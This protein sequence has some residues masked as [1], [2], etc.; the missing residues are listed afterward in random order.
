[1]ALLFIAPLWMGG[2]H[3]TGRLVFIT[4]MGVFA[5]SCFWM[6]DRKRL[7]D[8]HSIIVRVLLALATLLF[9]LQLLP[10]TPTVLN[11]FSPAVLQHLPLWTSDG[12]GAVELGPWNRLSLHPSATAQAFWMFA[13]Y[14]LLF[15]SLDR[16]L[17]DPKDVERLLRW[18]AAAAISMAVLALLQRVTSNG[19]FL[20]VYAHPSRDTWGV[21]HGT[22]AN[23]NHLAHFLA[24]GIGPLVWWLHSRSSPSH[25]TPRRMSAATEAASRH[26]NTAMQVPSM[27]FPSRRTD[28]SRH[29]HRSQRGDSLNVWLGVGLGFVVV[30]GLLTLSRA[31]VLAV[32]GALLVSLGLLAWTGALNGRGRFSVVLLVSLVGA[33]LAANGYRPLVEQLETLVGA[34]SLSDMSSGREQIWQ[35]VTQVVMDFPLLGVGAGAHADVYPIYFEDYSPVC[36]THA[37]SGYLQILEETGWIGFSLLCAGLLIASVWCFRA[38][39]H[40]AT[41]RERMLAGAVACSLLVSILHSLV[42]FVWYIPACMTVTV[43]L[44]A[45]AKCLERNW[46]NRSRVTSEA[47]IRRIWPVMSAV[48]VS[49]LTVFALAKSWPPASAASHWDQFLRLSAKV[50]AQPLLQSDGNLFTAEGQCTESSLQLQEMQACLENV[51]AA[52]ENN[53]RA[54]ARLAGTCLQRFELAQRSATNRM[55]LTQIREAALASNF[56][57]LQLQDEWLSRAVGRNYELLKQAEHHSRRAIQLSPLQGEV[58][59]YLSQLG[60]LAG[61]GAAAHQ[62]YLAQARIVRP[63][64]ADILMAAGSDMILKG[65]IQQATKC[66]ARVFRRSPE[67]QHQV[68]QL[69]AS[70]VPAE[71]F[72]ESFQP[73]RQGARELFVHYRKM[74]QPS[75]I[76]SAAHYYLQKLREQRQTEAEPLS[77]DEWVD[78]FLAQQSLGDHK[79][80]LACLEYAVH[81]DTSNYVVRRRL[82][83]ELIKQNRYAEALSHLRWCLRRKPDDPELQR[84]LLT[85]MQSR[86]GT[87]LR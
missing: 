49:L 79:A 67:Y 56:V 27:Q 78:A 60:F 53:A 62:D 17:R 51:L 45:C 30:A 44:L 16:W 28:G 9:V 64:E 47:Q 18:V 22:F 35:A 80:A 36:F 26:G 77:S 4:L 52:D 23:Q 24:L 72:L 73:D 19:K 46:A 76:K 84:D 32:A 39:R 70:R 25:S 59:M 38:I 71:F 50:E 33:T 63:H 11:Y 41:A 55:S 66:W 40:A 37:E 5:C 8:R 87:L 83:R 42:D 15:L 12:G 1:M 74:G 34:Q 68:I 54:H 3:P 6:L 31:G 2:R 69:L 48:A 65:Q 21:V 86:S 43:M 82:T 14:A 10:L 61:D 58:Y 75:Q 7:P 29:R 81:V 85:A 20:W 13:A 57:S